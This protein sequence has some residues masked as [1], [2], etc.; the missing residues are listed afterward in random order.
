MVGA[1]GCMW[2]IHS[3]RRG[4]LAL[5]LA[6]TLVVPIGLFAGNV[7][8]GQTAVPSDL[9][10]KS[11]LIHATRAGDRIVAVGEWGH[12]VLSD[13]NGETWRQAKMVPTR[14]TLTSVA[15]TDAQNGWA[16]GYDALI[17][18]TSDGGETWT[19]QYS[20][21]E[22]DDVLLTLWFENAEH[23]IAFGAF[24][25]TIET[26]DGG[27]TWTPRPLIEGS[28]DDFH[29][30]YAFQAPDGA[31]YIAAEAGFIYRSLDKG[32]SWTTL[33]TGY[34]GSFWAGIGM[35]DG[36]VVV[37]G[38][39]GNVY[40]SEDKGESWAVVKTGT[41]QSLTNGITLEDGRF[42]AVG[43]AGTVLSSSDQGRSFS[44]TARKDRKAY[45]A[46]LPVAGGDVLLFGEAGILRHTLGG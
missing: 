28:E 8:A 31:L 38:M 42:V 14:N 21:T 5:A 40:R 22:Q 15:F 17:L 46:V 25:L 27:K 11:L 18:Y 23:G 13:D 9:S 20:N 34:E 45:S 6:L 10:T 44:M 12:V 36:G 26:T 37:M 43:M 7:F 4:A 32:A 24:G 2:I 16:V 30:N 29:L 33:E 3:A 41:K 19:E 39:R 35:P 1:Q